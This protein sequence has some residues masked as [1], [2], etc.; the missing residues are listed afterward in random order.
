MPRI[1]ATFLLVLLGFHAL[2]VLAQ[3]ES[4]TISLIEQNISG[5]SHDYFLYQSVGAHKPELRL[6]LNHIGLITIQD[7]QGFIVSSV[8]DGYPAQLA[9]LR[10]GDR[11]ETVD[12]SPFHPLWSFNSQ[13]EIAEGFIPNRSAHQIEFDRNGT[14]QTVL[15]VS[16]FENLYDSYRSATINSIQEF[17][18]GNKVIGYLKLWNVSRSTNDLITFNS[19]IESLSH[20]DGLILDLRDGYGFIGS[21]HLDQFFPSR[22]SYFKFRSEV[23]EVWRAE[24]TARQ[25][26][27]Y[28][29]RA[30]VVIQNKGTR[31]GLELFSHQLAK[32]QRVVRLGE[33]TAGRLGAVLVNRDNNE[34]RYQADADAT[35]DELKLENVGLTPEQQVEFTLNESRA[36][37]PQFEAAVS[38]LM[39][40]M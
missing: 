28:Y 22:N 5:D 30:M 4:S 27:D 35:V 33:N 39:A 10:S 3:D 13:S 12:D 18:S 38:T 14:R 20:C 2:S 31:G 8:L 29:G 11:I 1:A 21:E 19:L 17:N 36:T 26:N 40:I 23:T 15:I 25:S 9:G 34:L 32:L 37:D 24:Q 7:N 6:R 16:V